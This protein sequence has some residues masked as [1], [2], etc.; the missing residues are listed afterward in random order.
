MADRQAAVSTSQIVCTATN[1]VEPVFEG[2]WLAEGAVVAAVGA[3]RPDMR[4]VD[5][6]TVDRSFVVVDQI[7]A[8]Q[9]GAGDLLQANLDWNRVL[10]LGDLLLDPGRIP[11]DTRP[12]LF[13][14][15]GLAVQDAL[16]ADLVYRKALERGIGAAVHLD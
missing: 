5:A 12:R 7:V 4:E 9:N 15:V 1:S 3:F 8:A 11:S 2:E 16:I 13:K 14:S 10:S 6:V